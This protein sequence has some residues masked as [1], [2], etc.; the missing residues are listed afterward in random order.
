VSAA[1]VAADAPPA[2]SGPSERLAPAD[3]FED[4]IQ[5]DHEGAYIT[6]ALD[7]LGSILH[8]APQADHLA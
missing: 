1:P 7:V 4:A 8:D 2:H 5:A 3:G 6:L